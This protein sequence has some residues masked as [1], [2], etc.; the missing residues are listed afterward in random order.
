MYDIIGDVHGQAG[1]LKDLLRKMGY[2]AANGYFSHPSRKAVFVGDFINRGPQIKETIRI[3]RSMTE[4]A[5]AYAILG[6]HEVNALFY[7]LLDKEGKHISKRWSRLRMDLNPTLAEFAGNKEKWNEQ[8]QW[9]RSLPL[10]LELDGIRVVHACWQDENIRLLKEAFC[11][12]PKLKKKQLKLIGRNHNVLAKAF[13]ETCKGIDFSLPKD[14]LIFDK[15]GCAHR[16]FRSRWWESPEGK[17]FEELS[18]ESRFELPKYQIPKELVVAREPYPADAPIVF[19]GHYCMRNGSNRIKHN[20]CC[21]DSCV[22]RKGKLTA[23]RW[24]GEKSLLD[25]NFVQ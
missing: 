14:L 10:F 5:A 3:I 25:E 13:W 16:S 15:E 22:S 23:Y 2:T 19:F 12:N 11:E 1:M 18:F 20:V 8:V 17:T 7:T 6:N 21:L 4:N 24:S 9:M